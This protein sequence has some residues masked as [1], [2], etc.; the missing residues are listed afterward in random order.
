M[1]INMKPIEV[2]ETLGVARS[3]VSKY[4]DEGL[5]EGVKLPNG[6]WDYDEESVYGFLNKGVPR[7]TACM[8]EFQQVS[9]RK[10]LKIKLNL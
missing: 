8:R 10:I 7:M 4:R 3:T 9:K 1:I 2:M 6:R 5:I